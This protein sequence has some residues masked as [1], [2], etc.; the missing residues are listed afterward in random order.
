MDVTVPQDKQLRISNL[1][2]YLRTIQVK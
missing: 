2:F 1:S